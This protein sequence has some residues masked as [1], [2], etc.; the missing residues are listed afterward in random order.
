MNQIKIGCFMYYLCIQ[1]LNS[2][3]VLRLN[4]H[5]SCNFSEHVQLAAEDK[6]RVLFVYRVEENKLL[7]KF[8]ENI[9]I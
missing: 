3:E 4:Q 2:A 9:F 7:R 5:L 6:C 8:I 1:K